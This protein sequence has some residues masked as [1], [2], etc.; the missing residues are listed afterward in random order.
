MLRGLYSAASGMDTHMRRLAVEANN[1]ANARTPGY[2]QDRVPVE[3]FA[4]LLRGRTDPAIPMLDVPFPAPAQTE[5]IG[6]IGSGV[7]PWEPVL[8]LSQGSPY[9]TGELLDL[10]LIGPGFFAVQT[11][12]GERYT[13]AGN[14][15]V[16]GNGMLRTAT[17]DLVLGEQGPIQVGGGDLSIASDGT[18]FVNGNAV[19]RLRLVEFDAPALRK[20]GEN[21]LAPQDPAVLPRPATAT[22]V[23]QGYLEGSN[24]DLSRTMV[25]LIELQRA[26][27][28]SARALQLQDQT[29]GQ[30]INDVGRVSGS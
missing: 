13:R 10:A 4:L 21:Y 28:L 12:D 14:F 24:V 29:L 5:L 16:D 19:A 8:D 7:F 17:G 27:E 25:R 6:P 3:S 30:A 26:Y 22:Q 9:Q 18:I 20:V 23:L 15:L 1:L 11:P 2:K